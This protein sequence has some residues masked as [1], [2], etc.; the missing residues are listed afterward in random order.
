ML[1]T[2]WPLAP[3]HCMPHATE[4]HGIPKYKRIEPNSKRLYLEP[5]LIEKQPPSRELHALPVLFFFFFK[6]GGGDNSESQ[7]DSVRLALRST[8]VRAETL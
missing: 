1:F 4:Y 5:N 3:A 6:G 7:P 8:P 2:P